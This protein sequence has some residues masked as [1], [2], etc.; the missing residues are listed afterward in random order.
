MDISTDNIQDS[1]AELCSLFKELYLYKESN[2]NQ[3]DTLNNKIS[4][5]NNVIL[6]LNLTQGVLKDDNLA[7]EADKADNLTRDAEN[8]LKL[9]ELQQQKDGELNLRVVNEELQLD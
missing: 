4:E 6:N 8:K 1:L 5:Q 9:K 7:L 2:L 3:V